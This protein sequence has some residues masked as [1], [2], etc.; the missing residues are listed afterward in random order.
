MSEK[1]DNNWRNLISNAQ[2]ELREFVNEKELLNSKIKALILNFQ[3][4]DSKIHNRLF[5][6]RDFYTEKRAT[7]NL[8]I[9]KLK[10]KKYE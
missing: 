2:K 1:E 7:Y 8:K 5:S 10:N 4:I 9:E 3:S 6:A